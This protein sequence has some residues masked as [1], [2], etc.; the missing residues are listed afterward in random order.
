MSAVAKPHDK[1]SDRIRVRGRVMS[2]SLARVLEYID[3]HRHEVMTQS[4]MELAAAI[5]T[6]DAT[7]VR[8]VQAA[9]FQGL[10]ELRQA[11]ATALG[12]GRTPID[13]LTR[14][15]ASIKERSANAVDQVFADHRE[16]LAA[17]ETDETRARIQ[18]AIQCLAPA[19]RVGVFGGG[20]TA[21]LGRYLALCLN[22][23]GR[24]T[25]VFDGYM[26]PLPEQLLDMRDVDAVLMLAFGGP[27]KEAMSTIAEARRVRV[28]IVLITNSTEQALTRHATVVV[29]V[30]CSQ[31]GRAIIHGATLVCLEAIILGMVTDDPPKTMLTL[32]RLGALRRSVYRR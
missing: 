1:L 9:G 32:E 11:L 18:D 30:M 8:A 29:P 13:T 28:P 27:Y 16:T 2:P 4:A 10:R 26:A 14:T 7:V 21:F 12:S 6:S 3:T 5:G 22:Q 31:A 24:P 17:L 19:N 15:V 20:A 25:A 23:I